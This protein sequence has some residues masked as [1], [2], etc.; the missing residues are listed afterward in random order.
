[1]EDQKKE[2]VVISYKGF[3]KDLICNPDDKPFQYK[4]GETYELDGEIEACRRG[5]HACEYPLNVFD[6]YAPAGN[7][8][9]IVEQSGQISREGGDTKVASSRITIK[10]E[11]TLP[12]I[13][14]AAI[15]YTFSRSKP[16]GETATGD[17]GAASATGDQGA[18]SATGD[19]G[20]ASA[21]GDQGAA[22]ATGDQGAASATG[23]QGAASATG[24]QG[25]ASATGNRGA[26]SATGKHAVAAAVGTQGRAKGLDGCAIVVC[27]RDIESD[28]DG[29]G[30][31]V[32]IRAAIVGQDGIKPDT[33]Y[34]LNADGE[35]V[36]AE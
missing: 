17:Q 20:A 9:A 25:A 13:I 14:K 18:A 34:S 5:F 2:E 23:D 26:A 15:D 33:W 6:Y 22:S 32:H 28:G 1:M 29:Y 4:I 27:Y 19:Q 8:F 30:R 24:Y 36:E 31:I 11:L 16:E 12:G 35:F 7:R 3:D 10:A 21:T